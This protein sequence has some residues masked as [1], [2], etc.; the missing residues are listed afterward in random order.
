MKRTL[1]FGPGGAVNTDKEEDDSVSDSHNQ[2]TM[3]IIGCAPV[4]LVNIYFVPLIAHVF[5]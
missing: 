3:V 5:L 2:W 4:G 1:P